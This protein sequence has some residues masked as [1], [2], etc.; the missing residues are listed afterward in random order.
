MEEWIEEVGEADSQHLQLQASS[1]RTLKGVFALLTSNL[2][3]PV[4]YRLVI[5]D[6]DLEARRNGGDVELRGAVQMEERGAGVTGRHVWDGSVLRVASE[7]VKRC[8]ESF[9][10][11]A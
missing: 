10:I 8:W 3:R 6:N 5:V 2:G 9:P 4:D 7:R 11:V 1:E